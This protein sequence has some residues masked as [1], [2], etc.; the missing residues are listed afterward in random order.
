MQT[1]TFLTI[2]EVVE[3]VQVSVFARETPPWSQV[4]QRLAVCAHCC[5]RLAE[6]RVPEAQRDHMAHLDKVLIK[7]KRVCINVSYRRSPNVKRLLLPLG[8]G[9]AKPQKLLAKQ[10]HEVNFRGLIPFVS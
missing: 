7:P 3:L 6:P 8:S 5:R 9:G 10:W 4:G 1:Y 2:F